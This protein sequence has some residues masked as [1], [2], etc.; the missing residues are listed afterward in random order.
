M[1]LWMN[2]LHGIVHGH[3]G[4]HHSTRT[5]DVHVDGLGRSFGFEEEELGGDDAGHLVCDLSMDADD[6]FAE[7]A[8]V[9]VERS[10][11]G[12]AVLKDDGDES[13]EISVLGWDFGVC[14]LEEGF[15]DGS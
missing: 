15:G 14:V 7:E 6:A 2:V 13:G 12:D 10:F 3:T 11:A 1:H 4:S 8:G 5:V 9:Y